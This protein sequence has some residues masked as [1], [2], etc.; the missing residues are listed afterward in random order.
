MKIGLFFGSFNPIHI[1]HLIIAETMVEETDLD[2]VWFVV[3]PHNPY[4][5]PDSLAHAFDRYEMVQRAISEDKRF[6]V[7]DIE[8]HLSKPN[9]TIH[10]LIHLK[11]KFPKYEFVLIM[12]SDNLSSFTKW[13]NYEE[14]LKNYFIYVYPRKNN[15]PTE[16]MNHPKI[17]VI[18]A[19]LLD[20][21]AS[22]IRKSIKENK[23]VLYRLP[24]GCWDFII[25]K[26]LW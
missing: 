13:K 18:E 7:S 12:G 22:A 20:I 21:S 11:E 9:F 14:I 16:F 19:P 23:T 15:S 24:K 3:S 6:A 8:F 1:G 25:Q 4:K 2:Q 17:K 5:N 10:T 26:K